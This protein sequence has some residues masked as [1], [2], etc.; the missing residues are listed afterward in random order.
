MI[1]TKDSEGWDD[2]GIPALVTEDM[3]D[4]LCG[5]HLSVLEPGNELDGGFLAWLCRS[6]PL[7]DQFKLGAN[8]VTRYGLGQ[9]PMKNAFVALPPF[10]TQQRIARFLDEKTARIDA[11]I[12]K[13]RALLDR[14]AEKRQALITP[15]VTKGLNLDAPMKPSRI[16]WLGDIPA[17]WE[18]KQLRRVRR[19][20][21]SGSR[22]WAAYYADGGDP[23]LRMTNVT[24]QGVE[25]DLDDLRFVSLEGVTEGTRTSVLEG[26]ILI[27]ITAELG[28]VA[29]VRKDIEGAYINQHLALFRPNAALCSSDY[30]VNFLSTDMARAQFMVSG[31]GGTKQGLGFEQVNNVVLGFPPLDEQVSIGRA[32]GELWQR[33]RSAERPL[34][35]SIDRLTE[36]RSA[37]IASAVT[38][39][40]EIPESSVVTFPAK[41][42]ANDAFKRSVLAAHI[43]DAFCDQPT[44]GR[45]KFQKTLHLCEAHLGLEEIGGNY[46]RRA[47]GPFDTQMMHSVHSQ[48]KRQ[49][50]IEIERRSN[51]KGYEY[52]R[53][54]KLDAYRQY[55]ERYFGE[56][57]ETIDGLLGLLAPMDTQQAEIVSTAY[58]AW[59]DL[60][61]DGH[62]ATDDEILHLILNDWA[63]EKRRIPEE[64]WRAAL[65]WMREKGLV[66]R[67]E[68]SHTKRG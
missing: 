19:Y 46:H 57:G 31:Q 55:Y 28:A 29:I 45:V 25:L 11:L 63:D 68:G 36:Y 67:G 20:M 33:F 8:G 42:E 58:A 4:V 7:N 47:A 62:D 38:G 18:V 52:R 49:G 10:E 41:R 26:D 61:L 39:K 23:F 54:P 44:F 66:P 2:I 21:T 27:T 34:V 16:D 5:Y 32:C 53:G 3:P 50:W 30:L 15:A 6:E 43:A 14:L 24:G 35:A 17:H 56:R 37:L 13:K 9:Y 1:I 12:E 60:L 51:S 40:L 64:R 65:G 48:L 59:N 22:D